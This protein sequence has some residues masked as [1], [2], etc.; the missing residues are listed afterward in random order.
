MKRRNKTLKFNPDLDNAYRQLFGPTDP[1]GCAICGETE[2]S[3]LDIHE[4]DD[5]NDFKVL[6][7]DCRCNLFEKYN[8]SEVRVGR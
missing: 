8:K 2:P 5:S 1:A 6:C 4:A 7:N 3:V